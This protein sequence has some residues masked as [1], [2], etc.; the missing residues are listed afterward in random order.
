MSKCYYSHATYII[1]VCGRVCQKQVWRAGLS[2]YIPQTLLDITTCP[3]PSY[4]HSAE[5]DNLSPFDSKIACLCIAL[6]NPWNGPL[7]RYVKLRVCACVRNAGNV[8]PA[9][10]FQR[11]SLVSDPGMYHGTC[12][13]H[14]P[15]CMSG[16]LTHG[17]GKNRSRHSRRNP[18]FYVSG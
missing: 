2:N 5:E 12:V 15:W 8:F 1:H 10:R 14:V 11:Q 17:G 3:C 16:S 7:T 13:M 9:T 4:L 18:Q 6:E